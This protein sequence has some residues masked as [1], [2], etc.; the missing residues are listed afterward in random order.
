[1]LEICCYNIES[2]LI[3]QNAGADRV[4]LCTGPAEG[5]TTPGPGTVR[6]ARRLLSID[7]YVI[8]RPR[9]GDFFYSENEFATMLHDIDFA[10]KERADGV[11]LGL[12][13]PDGTVDVERTTTLVKAAFPMQVTFHR[14]F[15]MTNDPFR[16]M[17]DVISTGAARIL[18]SGQKLNAVEGAGLIAGLVKKSGDRISIMAGS[19]IND[20]NVLKLISLTGV[21]EIHLS[22]KKYFPSEMKFRQ[23][24]L[25][26][27]SADT[28]EYKV[29]RADGN[30]IENVLRKIML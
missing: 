27:G 22:A 18:T 12:L 24:G 13:N 28:E 2:A 3:A 1:M 14:A 16:A 10:K 30:M 20:A 7:L 6:I 19:G 25:S 17:E 23:S 29:L 11:V 4:E 21:K 9:G 5:G 15:D 8:I 26:M